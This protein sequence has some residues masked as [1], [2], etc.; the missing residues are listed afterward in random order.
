MLQRTCTLMLLCALAACGSPPPEEQAQETG[1]REETRNIRNTSAVGY[2]GDAIADRLDQTLDA[3]ETRER[4]RQEADD[5]G[6]Y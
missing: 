2:S 1:G 5:A 6:G 3:T 4:Q